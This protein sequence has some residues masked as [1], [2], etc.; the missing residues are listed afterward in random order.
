MSK[1]E[2]KPIMEGLD[3]VKDDG[4]PGPHHRRVTR[5]IEG[6]LCVWHVELECGHTVVLVNAAMLEA[7]DFRVYCGECADAGEST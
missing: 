1:P 5:I 4:P 6:F 7:H 3:L 2:R